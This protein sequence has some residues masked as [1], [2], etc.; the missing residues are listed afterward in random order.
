M[1]KARIIGHLQELDSIRRDEYMP[2]EVIEKVIELEKL[3]T[4]YLAKELESPSDRR[5]DYA[6]EKKSLDVPTS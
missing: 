1:K 6:G 2:E 4:K 3:L 5:Y